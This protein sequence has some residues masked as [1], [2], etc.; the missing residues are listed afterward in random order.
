MCIH[1]IA[2]QGR[3]WPDE[4]GSLGLPAESRD[5]FNFSDGNPKVYDASQPADESGKAPQ[6]RARAWRVGCLV[7]PARLAPARLA[8][9][10]CTSPAPACT[11][12]ARSTHRCLCPGRWP[13]AP[14]SPRSTG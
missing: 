8:P 6:V 2:F 12:R 11:S 7:A 3:F 1:N 4:F 5:L 13:P 10:A 14:T 9:V